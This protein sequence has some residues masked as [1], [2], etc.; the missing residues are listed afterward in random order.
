MRWWTEVEGDERL[1]VQQRTLFLAEQGTGSTNAHGN[2]LV[3]AVR[4]YPLGLVRFYLFLM[5]DGDCTENDSR[6]AASQFPRST[7][8]AFLVTSPE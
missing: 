4:K 8:N 6:L 5:M 7:S 3:E 1:S 2:Q